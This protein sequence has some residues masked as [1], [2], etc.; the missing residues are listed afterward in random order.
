MLIY[1]TGNIRKY[2]GNYNGN[3]NGT[4]NGKNKHTIANNASSPTLA[5]TALNTQ[6]SRYYVTVAPTYLDTVVQW[7]G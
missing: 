4:Y 2:N 5:N 1:N 7:L 6:I 3:Y